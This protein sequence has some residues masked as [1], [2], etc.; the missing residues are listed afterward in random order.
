M[1]HNN[2]QRSDGSHPNSVVL[3]GAMGA[4]KHLPRIFTD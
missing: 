1:A 3:L 4:K 2:W